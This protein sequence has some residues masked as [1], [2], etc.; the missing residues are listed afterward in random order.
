MISSR[1]FTNISLH[2][3]H[4]DNVVFITIIESFRVFTLLQSVS[5]EVRK[6]CRESKSVVCEKQF[7]EESF[8]NK[9]FVSEKQ[10][11]GAPVW[12]YFV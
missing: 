10:K 12:W 3:S 9:I 11:T 4:A 5:N 1:A 6:Q 2:L 7:R 8:F